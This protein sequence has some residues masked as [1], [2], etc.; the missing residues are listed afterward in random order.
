MSVIGPRPRA[1]RFRIDIEEYFDHQRMKPGIVSWAQV[2]GLRGEVDTL[3]G[4]RAEAEHDLY[5]SDHWSLLLDLKILLMSGA[6]ALLQGYIGEPAPFDWAVN[7]GP[8]AKR[9]SLL[10]RLR[11]DHFS[12][13][14]EKRP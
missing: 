7:S 14:A 10:S 2:K 9:P 6:W 3:E 4:A 12:G 5:Y 8:E 13:S 11:R 1:L